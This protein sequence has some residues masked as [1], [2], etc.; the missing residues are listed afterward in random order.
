MSLKTMTEHGQ[1]NQQTTKV[2]LRD[3]S[4][5]KKKHL[6]DLKSRIS[7]PPELKNNHLSIVQPT[8]AIDPATSNETE[9]FLG[10]SL[11]RTSQYQLNSLSTQV[12]SQLH[13][14]PARHWSQSQSTTGGH[15]SRNEQRLSMLDLG[16]GKIESYTKLEKL[17]EGTSKNTIIADRAVVV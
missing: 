6:R 8:I 12:I 11:Q 3:H 7:L 10:K 14:S 5:K 16:Y 13:G 2:K 15:L 9:Q 4:N 17:G 1:N